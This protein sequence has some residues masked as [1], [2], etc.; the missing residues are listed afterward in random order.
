MLGLVIILMVVTG[1]RI[2]VDKLALQTNNIL[3]VED[4]SDSFMNR[5]LVWF[6]NGENL[7]IIRGEHSYGGKLGLFEISPSVTQILPKDTSDTVLGWLTVEEV[8]EYIKK[9]GDYER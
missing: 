5:V 9:V 4:H 2:N 1:W 8:N 7:S 3:R 6:K